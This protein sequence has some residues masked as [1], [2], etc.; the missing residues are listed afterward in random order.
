M[1]LQRH[2]MITEILY[3]D[4]NVMYQAQIHTGGEIILLKRTEK[5]R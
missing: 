3:G 4:V 5:R 1:I 2:T